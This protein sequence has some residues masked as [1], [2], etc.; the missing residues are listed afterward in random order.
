[1]NSKRPSLPDG[2]HDMERECFLSILI[3]LLGGMMIQACGWW[4]ASGAGGGSARNLERSR[5]QQLWLPLAP[6]S[7][8]AASLSGWALSEPDP[9]PE[10]A[11]ML[12]I[13]T[14]VPFALLFG[15]T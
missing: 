7:F 15:R 2:G 1:M 5:W 8:I 4:P 6:A 14:C 12:L 10:R 11:A 9:T 13:L 3:A